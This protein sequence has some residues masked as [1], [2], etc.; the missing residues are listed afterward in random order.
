MADRFLGA[1]LNRDAGRHQQA[2][3]LRLWAARR[4]HIDFAAELLRLRCRTPETLEL[5]HYSVGGARAHCLDLNLTAT[6]LEELD[7]ACADFLHAAPNYT[8]LPAAP[9]EAWLRIT[10]PDCRILSH[11]CLFADRQPLLRVMIHQEPGG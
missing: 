11:Y 1:R 6:T 8:T 4:P 2:V 3:D 10:G 7:Q 9:E 5:L